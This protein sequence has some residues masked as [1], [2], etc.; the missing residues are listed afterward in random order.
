[1]T[2][3][4]IN[5]RVISIDTKEHSM[6]VRYFTDKVTEDMLATT[7]DDSGKVI[8]NSDGSPISCRT[9]YYINVF[10]TPSP[11]QNTILGMIKSS[12]PSEWLYMQEAI[13]DSNVDTSM[14]NV[15]P[16]LNTTGSLVKTVHIPVYLDSSNITISTANT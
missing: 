10:E 16:L 14:T 13:L 8:R 15:I 11:D 7:I 5:Y 6:T 2:E 12:A 4:S 1:M 3:I 9:D